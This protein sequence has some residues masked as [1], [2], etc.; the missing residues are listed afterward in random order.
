MPL[1]V[2][3][4]VTVVLVALLVLFRIQSGTQITGQPVAN[5]RCDSGEQLSVHYHAHIDLIYRGQPATITAQ[6]GITGSCFY[7]M[8]THSE[9]GVIH[10]E[11][12]KDSANR[13]FTVG[14]FFAVWGQPL[15][16]RQVATFPV[17]RGDQVKVWVDGKPYTGRPEKIVLRSHTQ[18]VIEIGPTF[19]D[20]PTTNWSDPAIVQEAGAA[21]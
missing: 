15:N 17:G 6:T 11:A 19:V 18:V 8:H 2:G 10:I 21:G 7:W 16:S 13:Q 14:D 20:P 4:V 5:I 12:P 9:S 3:G 1:V